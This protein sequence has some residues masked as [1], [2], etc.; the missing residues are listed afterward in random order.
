M[1]DM[2]H[3]EGLV[4]IA[5]EGGGVYLLTTDLDMTGLWILDGVILGE[6]ADPF[7]LAVEAW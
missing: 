2:G 4:E 1:P 7:L 6:P 5:E 3:G